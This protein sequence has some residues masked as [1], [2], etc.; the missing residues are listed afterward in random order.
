MIEINS[1]IARIGLFDL[2]KYK[3][4]VTFRRNGFPK[5]RFGFSLTYRLTSLLALLLVLIHS[6]RHVEE[7]I[8]FCE[9]IV[10]TKLFASVRMWI[11]ADSPVMSFQSPRRYWQIP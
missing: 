5:S 10:V 4:G 8:K 2:R 6:R 1:Y 7:D 11:S 3:Y 9:E